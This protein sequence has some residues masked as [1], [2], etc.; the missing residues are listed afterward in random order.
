M[1]LELPALNGDRLC[2]VKVSAPLPRAERGDVDRVAGEAREALGDA[3]Y[4]AA[5]AEGAVG[6]PPGPPR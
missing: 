3:S 2:T 5:F 6:G 1:L 4:E